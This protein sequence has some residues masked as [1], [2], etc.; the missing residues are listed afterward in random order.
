MSSS[1]YGF[2]YGSSA[3]QSNGGGSESPSRET[4]AAAAPPPAAL[5]HYSSAPNVILVSHFEDLSL[6]THSLSSDAG[7]G[8]SADSCIAPP[9]TSSSAFPPHSRAVSSPAAAAS[10]ASAA[11]PSA[12]TA[13]S[14]NQSCLNNLVIVP[15]GNGRS[16]A[17]PGGQ[18]HGDRLLDRMESFFKDQQLCD[19]VLIAGE[20]T[21]SA[22]RLVLSAM[23]DYFSAMFTND[24]REANQREIRLEGVDAEAL[25]AL[26]VYMYTGK[27]ELVEETVENLLSTACLLQLSDVV[28]I[29][30]DFLKKQLHPSNCLGIRAFADA[31]GVTE[32]WR[33]A[34]EYTSEHIMEVMRN[35]EFVLL[36]T[37]HVIAL[38]GNEDLNIPCEETI[39]GAVLDWVKYD[40][41]ARKRHLGK[42]LAQVKLPLLSRQFLIDKIEINPIFADDAECQALIMEAMKYHLLPERRV[43][44]QSPRTRPRK[45]TCGNL[46]A[47]G[48]VDSA[49]SSTSIERYN[50]RTDKW[51]QVAA[52]SGRRLQF[53]VAVLEDKLYVVGGRDGLK[54]LNTVECYCPRSKRWTT[55]P[56][57][58]THRHGLG[59]SVL[60]GPLYAVGGHDGWSYLSTAERWDP[61][62]RVW[63]AICPMSTPRSTCGVA[64]VGRKL[65]AVGGRGGNECLSSVESY[66]P[67]TNRWTL[68]TPMT[69]R[70][71]G[72]GVAVLND[73]LYA[74]GGHDAP[75]SS[76]TA[77]K[78]S[79]C[80]RYDPSTDSWTVLS[81]MSFPRDAVGVSVL[82]DKV[83]AVGGYDGQHYL[84]SVETYDPVSNEWTEVSSL[85][86][87]RAGT[88]V[89]RIQANTLL[90]SSANPIE[91]S[92]QSASPPPA[93]PANP[94]HGS[95]PLPSASPQQQ[96]RQNHQQLSPPGVQ[97]CASPGRNMF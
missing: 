95:S 14:N 83:Y 59:V 7:G 52:M 97:L 30:S 94:R 82:G 77:V 39:L 4:V 38:L 89:V 24:V 55:V 25:Q 9:S 75:N 2:S 34:N 90:A 49:K 86:T 21:I 84:K 60:E 36:P 58:S 17:V 37:E 45:S 56:S 8:A 15:N 6:S 51:T 92:S 23:S 13:S 53:G 74:V 96:L 71:G 87:G 79:C 11:A 46:F 72:V 65:I 67:H 31:Q 68:M 63:S 16:R 12:T 42:L 35:Q 43:T 48:G 73:L 27:I 19:V 28:E 62:T 76:P 29:C 18:S 5:P 85:C 64:V 3:N 32:L 22:H 33:S 81:S 1:V 57:M 47:V 10:S 66:D 70:R 91:S 50:L 44:L 93:A 61:V 26:V 88:C 41:S 20:A 40:L 80:E 78:L 69:K 54:T